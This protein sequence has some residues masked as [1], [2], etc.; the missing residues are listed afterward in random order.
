[1]AERV[2]LLGRKPDARPHARRPV[3]AVAHLAGGGIM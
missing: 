2:S 1:M 3:R